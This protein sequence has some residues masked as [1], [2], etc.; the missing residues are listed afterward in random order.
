MK[1]K[2]IAHARAGDKGNAL[3]IGVIVYEAYDYEFLKRT[4]TADKVKYFFRDLCKGEVTRYELN[5]LYALNFVLSNALEG[6]SAGTLG[7]DALGRSTALALLEME[8]G[9]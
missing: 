3:N 6:G 4:L 2:E 7:I 5:G 8:L 9:E 1:L